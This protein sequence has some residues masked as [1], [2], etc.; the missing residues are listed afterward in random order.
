MLQSYCSPPGDLV[1][2]LTYRCSDP[3]AHLLVLQSYCSPPGAQILLFI[4]WCSNHIA[5]LLSHSYCSP[6]TPIPS[7]TQCSS[8]LAH[9]VF[10]FHWLAGY[11]FPSCTSCSS[12]IVL[13]HC[14]TPGAAVLLFSCIAKLL[15]LQFYCSPALL[16]SWCSCPVVLLYCSAPSAPA[17]LFSCLSQLVPQPNCS[18]PG[19]YRKCTLRVKEEITV[20]HE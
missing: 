1:P 2:L 14:S 10:Q 9:L 20:D 3:I 6:G 5:Y 13:L 4:S 18:T 19:N 12:P 8:P 7:L 16:N 17:L 11:C 15:V